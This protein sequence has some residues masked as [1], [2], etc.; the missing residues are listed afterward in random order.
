MAVGDLHG[1][2]QATRRVLRMASL[3]DEKDRWSG[4]RAVLVQTGDQLDRGDGER[5]ILDLFA[6][7]RSQAEAVGGRVVALNGNHET[8]NVQGDFRYVTPGGLSA[9]RGVQVR[10]PLAANAPPR[11][12]V[13]AE[14]LLPGGQ[15][16]RELSLRDVV[17][18]V[19]DS[20]FAHGGVLPEHVAY[21]I[22]RINREVRGW[23]AGKGPMPA[24]IASERAPV[25]VRDY[26]LEPVD[27]PTCERLR[28]VLRQLSVRRMVVGHTVQKGGITSGCEGSVYRIDVG[29][30]A[31]Y[32]PGPLEALEITPAG[33]R[34]LGRAAGAGP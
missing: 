22:D 30:A 26:S 14:A 32:G 1:D 23:M 3:L 27:G 24:V 25:W 7:L 4:G 20:V 31:H 15:Y 17:A 21:G 33:V 10:S 12:R 2:I 11:M 18:V 5:A 19:G 34:I 16:A 8:M 29:L 6:A 13:R 9:F 28:Q